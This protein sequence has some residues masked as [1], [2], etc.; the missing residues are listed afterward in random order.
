MGMWVGERKGGVGVVPWMLAPWAM[1][2]LKR[3]GEFAWVME[4]ERGFV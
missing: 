1:R 4:A 2:R 3:A